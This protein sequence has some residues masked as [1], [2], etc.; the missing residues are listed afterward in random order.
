[1]TEYTYMAIPHDGYTIL[2]SGTELDPKDLCTHLNA[3]EQELETCVGYLKDAPD[4]SDIDAAVFTINNLKQ[5]VGR[6]D[7]LIRHAL[8][9]LSRQDR[10][11]DS[12]RK[13]RGELQAE[14]EKALAVEDIE[15]SCTC[16]RPHNPN[17]AS[18]QEEA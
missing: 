11:E 12:I 15:S 13:L 4:H 6:K 9:E 16:G 5:R 8:Y 17:C 2:R 7:K 18:M 14:A 3:L 10:A 1:M